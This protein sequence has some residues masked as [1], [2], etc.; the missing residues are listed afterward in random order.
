MRRR[1]RVADLALQ[2][3]LERGNDRNDGVR[4]L[5]ALGEL[6]QERG[7]QT[8]LELVLEDGGR[9]GDAPGLC[10]RPAEREERQGRS[11]A[12]HG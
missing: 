12:L 11:C 2:R 4:D 1:E 7:G 8:P 10:E 6:L 5:R 9:D 3:G